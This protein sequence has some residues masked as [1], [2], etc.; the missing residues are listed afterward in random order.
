MKTDL[1]NSDGIPQG[2]KEVRQRAVI[3]GHAN[4]LAEW[5]EKMEK[6]SKKPNPPR[7]MANDYPYLHSVSHKRFAIFLFL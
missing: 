2:I 4:G 1:A 6:P 3:G 5:K 7:Q